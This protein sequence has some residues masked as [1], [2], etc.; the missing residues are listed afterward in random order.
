[1]CKS[2]SPTSDKVWGCLHGSSGLHC[3]QDDSKPLES[4]LEL[5]KGRCSFDFPKGIGFIDI[6]LFYFCRLICFYEDGNF[7]APKTNVGRFT[8]VSLSSQLWIGVLSNILLRET[9]NGLSV[10]C[11]TFC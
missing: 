10:L 6:R 4:D 3:N 11:I 5:E 9:W 1:M 7:S 8:F 2:G